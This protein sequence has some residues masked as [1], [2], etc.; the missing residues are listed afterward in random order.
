MTSE[1]IGNFFTVID[2]GAIDDSDNDLGEY[3][4]NI[5]LPGSWAESEVLHHTIR[6]SKSRGAYGKFCPETDVSTL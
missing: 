1:W 5:K 4:V 6:T 2:L 3:T